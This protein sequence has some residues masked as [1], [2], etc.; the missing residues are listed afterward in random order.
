M[1][2]KDT[3]ALAAAAVVAIR[4]C[5]SHS[6]LFSP[7]SLCAAEKGPQQKG[8]HKTTAKVNVA[9][10]LYNH[11]LGV[12]EACFYS[13]EGKGKKKKKEDRDGE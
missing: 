2:I 5:V 6:P 1:S 7:S 3:N 10:I 4:T 8:F 12:V 9:S 11:F 13:M